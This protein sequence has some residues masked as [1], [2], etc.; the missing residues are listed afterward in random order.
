MPSAQTTA[1]FYPHQTMGILK[2]PLEYWILIFVPGQRLFFISHQTVAFFCFSQDNSWFISVFKFLI[3]L[4]LFLY[5]SWFKSYFS[6]SLQ[7]TGVFSSS[8]TTCCLYLLRW[9]Q[10]SISTWTEADFLYSHNGCFLRI[11]RQWLILF[12][13]RRTFVYFWLQIM[14]KSYLISQMTLFYFS[15]VSS[16]HIISSQITDRFLIPPKQPLSFIFPHLKLSTKYKV[17]FY[18]NNYLIDIT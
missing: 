8:Q 15:V 12:S 17:R 6:I 2:F 13:P 1:A 11:Y 18:C 16:S 5:I 4:D 10:F 14:V 3:R 7:T 9:R